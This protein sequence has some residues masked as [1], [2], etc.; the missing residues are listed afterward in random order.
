MRLFKDVFQMLIVLLVM[1]LISACGGTSMLCSVPEA[2][3]SVI[4]S[5]SKEINTTPEMISQTL[6]VAN[7]AAME[8]DAYTAR[9]ADKFING[10]ITEISDVRKLGKEVSYLDVVNYIQT[11]FD[12][13]PVRV[14]TLFVVVNPAGLYE[15]RITIP[16]TDYDFEL[17]LRH[18]QRQK[19]ILK[20]YM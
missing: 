17:I 18:L 7:I 16:L 4:C 3:N 12:V 20:A 6:M 13:L 11:K 19:N 14:Q 8:A 10:L 15:Q 2:E 9:R 5:L 1:F